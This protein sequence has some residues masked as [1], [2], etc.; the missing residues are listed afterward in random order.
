MQDS[1]KATK[2]L[3]V[4]LG[5]RFSHFTPWIDREGYGYSIFDVSQFAPSCAS[6]F[7]GFEWHAK[8]PSVPVS[9]FPTRALF[10]QPRVGAAYDV[11]GTGRTVLRGGWG[12][13]VYHSGQFTSGLDASA[14]VTQANLS[15]S[16][17]VGGDRLPNQ[18]HDRVGSVRL[19]LVVSQCLTDAVFSVGRELE[20]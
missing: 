7:C 11:W 2:K 9:G 16:T 14:G 8:D 4:E 13:F 19:I 18:S 17:W 10:Y 3:T 5:V 6:D 12:Q 15:P 1:W 20:R